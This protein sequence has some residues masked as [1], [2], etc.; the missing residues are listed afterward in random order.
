MRKKIKPSDIVVTT[1]YCIYG[2]IKIP[3]GTYFTVKSNAI[4]RVT[5]SHLYHVKENGKIFNDTE[6]ELAKTFRLNDIVSCKG[7]SGNW[8]VTKVYVHNENLIYDL[9]STKED[10]KIHFANHKDLIG[11]N[12]TT[13][14]EP[15]DHI[16]ILA[17]KNND[18]KNI[19]T[20]EKVYQSAGSTFFT[21]K[22][23]DR[24]FEEKDV[25]IWEGK[26]K[27]IRDKFYIISK[28][29]RTNEHDL[30]KFRMV[31]D[32]IDTVSVDRANLRQYYDD[33]IEKRIVTKETIKELN[34]MYKDNLEMEEWIKGKLKQM[35][36][37][38]VWKVIQIN[39][40]AR[41]R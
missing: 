1:N 7:K 36:N 38:N 15:G 20:V 4:G 26:D 14:I 8:R 18:K 17:N 2:S 10:N 12:I 5:G 16:L 19:Y 27:R 11:V 30:E 13:N 31:Q 37:E 24:S 21:V 40:L 39:G 25:R 34:L 29:L 23:I 9:T 33:F 35:E 32:Q 22:E 3:K 41:K 6:V 28:L